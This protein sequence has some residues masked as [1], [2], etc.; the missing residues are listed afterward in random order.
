MGTYGGG[1]CRLD[2]ETGSCF[3]YHHDTDD[4]TTISDNIVYSI[5]EDPFGRFWIGTNSGLNMFYPATESFRRFGVSEGLAN[6]VIY[7]ILPDELNR[8][9]LSSNMGISRFDLET[10]QVKNFD[11]NDG[12]QSNEFNGGAYH[13]GHSGK[14]YFG[15]VYG[16]NVIDP[17]DIEPDHNVTQVTL[18]KLEILG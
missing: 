10:F 2:T 13:K 8:I 12:L 11:M 1:L 6:E 5:Y 4:P 9:W 7:G 15:G 3:S 17:G 16:L 18:T 14:L